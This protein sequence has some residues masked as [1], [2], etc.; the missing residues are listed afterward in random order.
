VVLG[1]SNRAG[2][3]TGSAKFVTSYTKIAGRLPR[4]VVVVSGSGQ[5]ADAATRVASSA[6]R[7]LIE[8][9]RA[10]RAGLVRL[11]GH[12]D[13]AAERRTGSHPFADSG[14]AP[15]PTAGIVRALDANAR[16]N[17]ASLEAALRAWRR[18][19]RA[20]DHLR[21]RMQVAAM[22]DPEVLGTLMSFAHPDDVPLV[23]ESLVALRDE[24]LAVQ[25]AAETLAMQYVAR[26][27]D[28]VGRRMAEVPLWPG[29]ADAGRDA[30]V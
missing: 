10:V 25:A 21:Y 27:F 12:A 7:R 28:H 17:N 11:A 22:I 9:R 14:D 20:P 16:R 4:S 15:E 24:P 3:L 8:L 13:H 19:G 29:P 2:D 6:L 18:L 23:F 30:P 1:A 5:T 26:G